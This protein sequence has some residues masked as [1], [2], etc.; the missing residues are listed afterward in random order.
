[1][2]V[3]MWMEKKTQQPVQPMQKRQNE[4]ATRKASFLGEVRMER[5]AGHRHKL[6]K[7][8]FEKHSNGFF[9]C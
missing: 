3:K 7:V 6:E 1:M 2:R 5:G 4:C 8:S 9:L